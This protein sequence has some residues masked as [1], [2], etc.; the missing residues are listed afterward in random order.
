MLVSP[1]LAK[2]GAPPGDG[3]RGGVTAK[4]V[5]PWRWRDGFPSTGEP[6]GEGGWVWRHPAP[7][8][9]PMGF[10]GSV[11][12]AQGLQ[13]VLTRS[14]G[15]PED[16]RFSP[17]YPAPKRAPTW[18]SIM[19][20]VWAFAE[21]SGYPLV[22]QWFRQYDAEAAKRGLQMAGKKAVDKETRGAEIQGWK[23]ALTGMGIRI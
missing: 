13:D 23:S 10:K 7:A 11:C 17:L 12:I 8:C 4:V 20:D 19:D 3:E 22:E 14:A 16:H 18:G 5:D 1:T 6:D 21:K 2:V 9:I 15:L